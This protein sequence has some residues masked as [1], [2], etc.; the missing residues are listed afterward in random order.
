MSMRL[1]KGWEGAVCKYCLGPESFVNLRIVDRHQL[2]VV[3][4]QIRLTWKFDDS[5]ESH[6]TQFLVRETL[7]SDFILG[8][9]CSDEA[10]NREIAT[11]VSKIQRPMHGK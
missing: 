2:E 11:P 9:K 3:N 6:V 7:E 1:N 8:K 5:D 10:F 4:Q